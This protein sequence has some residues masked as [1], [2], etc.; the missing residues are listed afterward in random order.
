MCR[1]D[2]YDFHSLMPMLASWV[3]FCFFEERLACEVIWP[4]I[5]LMEV[6]WLV[7]ARHHQLTRH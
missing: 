2:G 3:K 4:R 5:A 7:Q 1:I 6:V